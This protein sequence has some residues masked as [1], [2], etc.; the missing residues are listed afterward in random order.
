LVALGA[1]AACYYPPIGAVLEAE[2][3]VPQDADVAGAIG[4]AVGSIRQST[5]ITI[6]QPSDGVFRV[7]LVKGPSDYGDLE[8]A[9][10]HAE[11]AA[12]DEA[13]H[14]AKAAGG[15]D[16]HTE[17]SR[18]VESIDVGGG[19]TLFIEAVVSATASSHMF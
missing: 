16:I 5:R 7:H 9:L 15:D 11:R 13:E 17:T 6:T 14:K 3:I 18:K 10:D 2:L 19:K 1:S 12:C 4:A 8:A